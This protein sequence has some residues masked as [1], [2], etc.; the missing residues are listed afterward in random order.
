MTG[1]PFADTFI[2]NQSGLISGTPPLSITG[3]GGNDDIDMSQVPS[4]ATF[5]MPIPSLANNPGPPACRISSGWTGAVCPIGGSTPAVNFTGIPNATG[6]SAGGDYF[7]AGTGATGPP[8]SLTEEKSTNPGTLDYSLVPAAAGAAGIVVDVTAPFTGT[9]TSGQST[10][11][12]ATFTNFGTFVGTPDN[13]SFFESAGGL[14][15]NINGGLGV[16]SL[17]LTG[18]PSNTV[19][20]VGARPRLRGRV[21]RWHRN[22]QRHLRHLRVHEQCGFFHV[23]V[24][25][26][27]LP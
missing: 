1:T 27:A 18:A 11:Q 2:V 16:N 15:Y 13:D 26:P 21:Q 4:S 14:N 22:R 12:N 9:V 3:N 23:G 19:D 25:D 24:P 8:V 5:V 20:A 6:T 7:Y 17:D 10:I